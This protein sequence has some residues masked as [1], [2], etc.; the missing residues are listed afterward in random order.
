MVYEFIAQVLMRVKRR[1]YQMGVRPK[2]GS[3]WFSPSLNLM[4]GYSD[5]IKKEAKYMAGIAWINYEGDDPIFFRSIDGTSYILN[6]N[7]K[8]W[9]RSGYD[10]GMTTDHC[11]EFVDM[12]KHKMERQLN[13][14]PRG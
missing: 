9:Q 8:H 14:T 13:E 4:Y 1:L 5:A 7:T 6:K 2:V 10:D 11:I 3:I 12:I